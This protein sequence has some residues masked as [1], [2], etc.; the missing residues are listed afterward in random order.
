V[1]S[2]TLGAI[3]LD[4]RTVR[5]DAISV[6][7]HGILAAVPHDV[8]ALS[9]GTAIHELVSSFRDF[10]RQGAGPVV[11]IDLQD[12]SK[13]R[14]PNLYFLMR[15]VET[16][17][18]ISELV[19]TEARGGTDGYVVG[20]CRPDDLRRRVELAVPHYAEAAVEL[21][22]SVALDLDKL[23]QAQEMGNSYMAF[24]NRLGPRVDA[25]DDPEH[26]WVTAERIRTILGG[27]LSITAVE[28]VRETL[29]SERVR[30][31]IG[32]PHRFVPTTSGG[33]LS[34]LVDR[35]AVALVVA[36]AA[37]AHN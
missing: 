36:R 14:L 25:S 13:W 26:G 17:P 18:V 19:F 5:R 11:V 3:Q 9:S 35:E 6:P 20:T 37:L 21:S 22:S 1:E 10:R 31:V 15:L 24:L 23:D 12:G 2:V 7:S 29:D 32:C 30:A 16:E 34:G 33:R 28:L 27:L 4:I 8:A